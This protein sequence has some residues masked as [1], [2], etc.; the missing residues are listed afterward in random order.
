[1]FR[2][3]SDVLSKLYE[4]DVDE[5][6]I[7]TSRWEYTL[8]LNVYSVGSVSYDVVQRKSLFDSFNVDQRLIKCV[9]D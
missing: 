7:C 1:M 6:S 5:A 4:M 3:P 9:S 2:I 8:F